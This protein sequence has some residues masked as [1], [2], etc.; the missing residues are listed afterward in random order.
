MPLLLTHLTNIED[1]AS[2]FPARVAFKIPQVNSQTDEIEQWTD[3]TFHQFLLD[4]EHLARYWF[5][6]LKET[7]DI[8]QRSVIA[9]CFGG[10]KYL[11][12][13][14]VYAISRA[15][16]IPQLINIFE[17]ADFSVI[18]GP[19][20]QANTRAFIH[21]SGY[22]DIVQNIPIPC[23]TLVTIVHPNDYPLP[24]LPHVT[25]SDVAV[26]YQTSGSASAKSKIV[27]C[28]YTWL[29]G[30]VHKA[31]RAHLD[32]ANL[33]ILVWHGSMGFMAQFSALISAIYHTSCMVQ[34]KSGEPSTSELVD[35]INRCKTNKLFLFP[36]FLKKHIRASYMDPETLH[37]LSSVD[38][39]VYGGGSFGSDEEEEW[40]WKNGINLVNFFGTTECSGLLIS[41]GLRKSRQ[42][43]LRRLPGSCFI[44]FIP[45]SSDSDLLELIVPP[46]APDCPDV[47]FRS[48]DGDYHTNDLFREVEPG[49]YVFCGR[50]DDWFN[51]QDCDLCDTK[52]IEDNV[53]S[54]CGDIISDC[55][56][57]GNGRPSPV[58]VVEVCSPPP[59]SCSVSPSINESELKIEIYHR[60][61]PF[62][63]A[64]YPHERVASPDM[65]FVVP[66]G[67]LPRTVTKATV[68][69]KVVEETMKE[70]LD[71]L[72]SGNV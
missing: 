52:S 32:S 14:H 37:A 3:I 49:S 15:G 45:I 1:A 23:F 59:P 25:G 71:E 33:D 62:H 43:Y 66:L 7:S 67:T 44:K 42:N 57:V 65:I 29:D 17:N 10:F 47:S 70:K 31:T 19:L 11:D 55:V 2:R 6:V 20:E 63:A 39:I 40:A 12:V 53:R 8:P 54:L 9:L 69:R 22:S 5:H 26:I 56:V 4:I 18:Q 38:E 24:G 48:S 35:I 27:P 61:H 28:N 58:L 68:R 21:E 50:N 30:I 60:I 16:Y 36:H 41:D 72:F 46:E 34:Y 64:R 51:M 13:V